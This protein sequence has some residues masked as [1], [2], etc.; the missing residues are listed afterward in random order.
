[1]ISKNVLVKLAV[2]A[3]LVA[4]ALIV[5]R[6]LFVSPEP[7]FSVGVVVP[8]LSVA[9]EAGKKIF[10]TNCSSCHGVNAAGTHHGPPLVHKIYEPNHHSDFTFFRAVRR[11]VRGHHW[12]YGDMAAIPGVSD[13]DTE[14]I[15]TYVRE[16]Q[17]ANGVF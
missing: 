1:M 7:K 16:L 17:K 3:V 14:K 8:E 10:D 11:G 5:G 15:V 12:P 13:G 6:K 4:G 2:A 9:A